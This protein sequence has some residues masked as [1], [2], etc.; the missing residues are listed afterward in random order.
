MSLDE[1]A[2]ILETAASSSCGVRD[3]IK[4]LA[5]RASK[6]IS[7]L[8][9]ME[10]ER[11]I[12][13]QNVSQLR[14][15]R[16]TKNVVCTDLGLEFL[17]AHRKL[18]MKPVRARKEDLDR[19]VKDALYAQ[20]LVANGHLPFKLFMELNDIACNIKISSEASG[21]VRK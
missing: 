16:P 1:K 11:L 2:R 3:V 13:F 7:L 15:G 14:K 20:R 10:Q 4:T 19:A 9:E 17:E 8:K 6:V 21:T 18:R 5:C 12:E